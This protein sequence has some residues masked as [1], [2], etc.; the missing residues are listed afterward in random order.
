MKLL[1]DGFYLT[2]LYVISYKDK[3]ELLFNVKIN[4]DTSFLLGAYMC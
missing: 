2:G 4:A 1:K 3:K